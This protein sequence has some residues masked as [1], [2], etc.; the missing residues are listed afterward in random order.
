MSRFRALVTI[1][2]EL[3][4]SC[5]YGRYATAQ[6]EDNNPGRCLDRGPF[7]G[8]CVIAPLMLSS[9]ACAAAA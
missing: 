2:D 6:A 4:G 8:Y 3:R 1:S 9:I 5:V 7:F